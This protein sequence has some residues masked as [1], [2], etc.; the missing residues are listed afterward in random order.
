M[1]EAI[2]GLNQALSSF[3]RLQLAAQAKHMRGAL[4]VAGTPMVQALRRAA[5]VGDVAHRTYKGRVVAPGFLS[6]NIKKSAR[7]SRDKRRAVLTIRLAPEAWYGSLPEYGGVE[8]DYPRDPWFYPAVAQS[9]SIVSE[10]YFTRLAD[11]IN[12]AFRG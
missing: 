6:R 2:K 5:P 9:E 8:H 11:R 7:V 3:K 4:S 12:K 1:T 10:T